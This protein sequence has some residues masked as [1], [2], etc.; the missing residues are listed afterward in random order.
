MHQRLIPI[1]LSILAACTSLSS[2]QDA[3]QTDVYGSGATW[4]YEPDLPVSLPPFRDVNANWKQR[5]DQAYVY[6]EYTG[7]YFE[8]GR[9]LPSVHQALKDAKITPSGPPFALFYDDPGK[10]PAERLRS[11]ACVPVDGM[12]K[13][14]GPLMYDVLP[15]Q[16][17]AYAVIGGPYPE[18]PRSYPGLYAY[19]NKM[20]W[21]EDGPVREIYLV[22]PSSVTDYSQLMT[23]VQ[24]P[25]VHGR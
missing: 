21:V 24:I 13:H 8:T 2:T 5:I 9:L 25:A 4:L 6:V 22:P 3:Q 12:P 16:T 14:M 20:G 19:M 1:F 17:V 10:V 15:S 18:V 23:E 7:P 11:R